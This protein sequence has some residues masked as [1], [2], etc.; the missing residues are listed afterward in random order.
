M[1][2]AATLVDEF[3]LADIA[4]FAIQRDAV[5]R[6]ATTLSDQLGLALPSRVVIE[7]ANGV[8][9]QALGVSMEAAFSVLRSY[10]RAQNERL[11]DVAA[12]VAARELTSNDLLAGTGDTGGPRR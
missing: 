9:G 2:L 5:L 3:A 8:L 7:Q 1:E 10:A 4:T 11:V 12:R 6:R